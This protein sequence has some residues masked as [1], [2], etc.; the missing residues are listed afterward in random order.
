MATLPTTPP[1][2]AV[3]AMPASMKAVVQDRYGRPDHVL[4]M[5]AISV[6]P[7][8]IDE[9]L[10]RVAA[11]SIHVGDLVSVE[12]EPVVARMA[13]GL[14]K[15]NNR[16]PGTDIAGTVVAVGDEVKHIRVGDEVFGWCVGAFAEYVSAPE[17]HFV[18]RPTNLTLVHASAVGV[19]ACAALQ[20]LRGRVRPGQ[21]VLINGASGGLGSFAVQIARAFGA[22]VTA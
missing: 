10:V 6:P 21:K 7:V 12:G 18:P 14:R 5:E 2:F 13:T 20:L 16:V 1:L 11:A 3:A 4:R 19:S 9:V 15:P 17:D 8:K 22:E